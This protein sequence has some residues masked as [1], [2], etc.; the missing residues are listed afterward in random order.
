MPVKPRKPQTFNVKLD[1]LSEQLTLARRA[2][3]FFPGQRRPGKRKL[4]VYVC[5][6]LWLIKSRQ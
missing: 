5:V 2:T 6:G 4:S 1:Y 3:G